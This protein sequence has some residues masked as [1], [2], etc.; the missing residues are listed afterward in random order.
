MT[1]KDAIESVGKAVDAPAWRRSSWARSSPPPCRC[2][3]PGRPPPTATRPPPAARPGHPAGTGAPRRRR[4]HP[5]R[6]GDADLHQ[7]RGPRH[8]RGD[9]DVPQLQSRSRARGTVALAEAEVVHDSGPVRRSRT[10]ARPRRLGPRSPIGEGQR[11]RPKAE[12]R[13]SMPECRKRIPYGTAV[14]GPRRVRNHGS[15]SMPPQ[16]VRPRARV[17]V[18]LVTRPGLGGVGAPGLISQRRGGEGIHVGV[19]HGRQRP[20]QLDGGP[21]SGPPRRCRRISEVTSRGCAR[22]RDAF[23]EVAARS[24]FSALGR[25]LAG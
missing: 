6:R 12:P 13:R 11:I 4:H 15:A 1:F 10:P 7:R 20:G 17:G 24:A 18:R 21:P 8:H 9:T 22:R 19:E 14:T 25:L 16:V 5:H 2:G 3:A 23:S